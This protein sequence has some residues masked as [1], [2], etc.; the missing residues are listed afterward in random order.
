MIDYILCANDINI[1]FYHLTNCMVKEE[2]QIKT[3]KEREEQRCGG[4]DTFETEF[5]CECEVV[6]CSECGCRDNLYNMRH[7]L[8]HT[9]YWFIAM[10]FYEKLSEIICVDCE[11]RT[12]DNDEEEHGT[13][14]EED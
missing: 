1:F 7:P 4:C 2:K 9:D 5:G 13:D 6:S 11:N 12:N 10:P 14:N 3:D 8:F